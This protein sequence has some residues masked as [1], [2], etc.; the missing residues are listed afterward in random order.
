MFPLTSTKRMMTQQSLCL[1]TPDISRL[2][3]PDSPAIKRLCVEFGHL[4][5]PSKNKAHNSAGDLPTSIPKIPFKLPTEKKTAPTASVRKSSKL[6]LFC[7]RHIERKGSTVVL[8]ISPFIEAQND[9][10]TFCILE[11]FWVQTRVAVGDTVI[12]IGTF[13]P[14]THT[15]VVSDQAN[16]LILHPDTLISP[17]LIGGANYC[18]RKALLQEI[19]R[20]DTSMEMFIGTLVHDLMQRISVAFVVSVKSGVVAESSQSILDKLLVDPRYRQ[21]MYALNVNE[22]R[23][24]E[25]ASGF[26][27]NIESWAWTELNNPAVSIVDIEEWIWSPR[28]GVKG[29]VDMTLKTPGGIKPLEIKTGK[30]SYAISHTGQVLLYTLLLSEKYRM[31]IKEGILYYAKSGEWKTVTAKPAELS[32][33]VRMRNDISNYLKRCHFVQGKAVMNLPPPIDSERI[34]SQCQLSTMCSLFYKQV[35]EP[36]N[37]IQTL[38]DGHYIHQL[39]KAKTSHLTDVHL[40]YFERWMLILYIETQHSSQKSSVLDLWLKKDGEVSS[41]KAPHSVSG[42]RITDISPTPNQLLSYTLAA[43]FPTNTSLSVGDL[44]LLREDNNDGVVIDYCTITSI[45]KSP[46]TKLQ[47]QAD[48]FFQDPKLK[49]R[50]L[51]VDKYIYSASSMAGAYD[52]LMKLME[53]GEKNDRLRKLFLDKEKPQVATQMPKKQLLDTRCLIRILPREQQAVVVKCLLSLDYV[54]ID[55]KNCADSNTFVSSLLQILVGCEQSVLFLS[56]NGSTLD[57]ILLSA[58]TNSSVKLLRL[59]PASRMHTELKDLSPEVLASQTNYDIFAQTVRSANVVATTNGTLRQPALMHRFFDVC[60]V[61]EASQMLQ[62]SLYGFLMLA[63]RFILIGDST[64][65][66]CF[67]SET[68]VTMGIE[69]SLMEC[70]KSTAEQYGSWLTI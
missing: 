22:E 11:G 65:K 59:G 36:R 16:Y 51:R 38:P 26:I 44:V 10:Q 27:P 41:D 60:L 52:G 30:T 54:F 31:D 14:D 61:N 28:Y 34:C 25:I 33:L 56:A 43:P 4:K 20:S 35:E 57:N 19:V 66:P 6:P 68:A 64:K 42:L 8:N 21:D 55:T 7:V 63:Q 58:K 13:D 47:V 40:S 32:A 49:S 12:I 18:E 9:V 45:E 67:R 3:D 29:R 5:S 46:L 23:V 62:P 53:Q 39:L 50:L 48:R 37:V 69:E 2:D 1:S 17:T 24:R 70:I 15:C